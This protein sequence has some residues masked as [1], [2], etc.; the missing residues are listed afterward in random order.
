MVVAAQERVDRDPAAARRKQTAAVPF[1][2][3]ADADNH[4]QSLDRLG[5]QTGA[6]PTV[7]HNHR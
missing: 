1:L 5:H 7:L 2:P 3:G 6:Q 4:Q